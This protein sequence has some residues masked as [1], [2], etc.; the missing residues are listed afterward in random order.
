MKLTELRDKVTGMREEL[1]SLTHKRA[2]EGLDET[3]E[4][5]FVELLDSYPSEE[6][7][8]RAEQMLVDQEPQT[9]R[10]ANAVEDSN[11]AFLDAVLRCQRDRDTMALNVEFRS[12]PSA[13]TTPTPTA[14]AVGITSK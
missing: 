7:N 5:R 2:Q 4:K 12:D 11:E 9:I 1:R 13:G 3:E 10:S 14:G 8:L 6:K